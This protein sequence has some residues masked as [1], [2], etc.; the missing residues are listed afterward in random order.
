[1]YIHIFI[2]TYIYI[3]NVRFT[4]FTINEKNIMTQLKLKSCSNSANDCNK[5]LN[6]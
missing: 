3:Y 4:Y 6:Y 5:I 2:F 1:M